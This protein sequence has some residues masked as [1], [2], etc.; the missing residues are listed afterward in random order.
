MK[1]QFLTLEELARVFEQG[2]EVVRKD[3]AGIIE[4]DFEWNSDDYLS[5]FKVFH[6]AGNGGL[7]VHI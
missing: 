2:K 4:S 7:M 1:T 6:G 3:H 5:V